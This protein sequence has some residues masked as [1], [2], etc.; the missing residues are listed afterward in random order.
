MNSHFAE[1]IKRAM[2]LILS[3]IMIV[4]VFIIQFIV[5][6]FQE[7]FNANEFLSQ[8]AVNLF[9]LVATAII[10]MNTGTDRAKTEE[11][12]AYNDNCTAYSKKVAAIS[13]NGQLRAL[14]EFCA[15]K[16]EEMRHEK[17]RRMLNNVGLDNNDYAAKKHKSRKELMKDGLSRRQIRQIYKIREGRIHVHIIQV[18][19][20]MADSKGKSEYEIAYNE[21]ADKAVRLGLRIIKSVIMA[22]VLALLA[23]DLSSNIKD[24]SVWAL[25]FFKLTTILFTAVSSEREGYLQIAQTRNRIILQRIEFLN[26]FDEWEKIPRLN[27]AQQA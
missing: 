17:I 9:L 11:P 18:M 19:E 6:S 2:P 26:E 22:T 13:D 12:S 1:K 21:E 24:L 7:N 8:L 25:F 27:A 20:L 3:G 4:T 15:I 10:W 5:V 23:F 16:T 14:R